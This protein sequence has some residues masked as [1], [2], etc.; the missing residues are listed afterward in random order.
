VAQ[1]RFWPM[2]AETRGKGKGPA[3][4]RDGVWRDGGA[5]GGAAT[6]TG[7]EEGAKK[8]EEAE[9]PASE[10]SSSDETTSSL[11]PNP[12]IFERI[13]KGMAEAPGG[14]VRP[15]SLADEIKAGFD[16]DDVWRPLQTRGG[17]E[18]IQSGPV[19]SRPPPRC[20]T[21]V[22]PGKPPG[23]ARRPAR[24]LTGRAACPLSTRGGTRLVRLVRGRGG[25]SISSTG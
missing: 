14:S 4:W 17:P 20:S 6:G 2:K 25:G 16:V 19:P 24:S 3:W 13:A 9:G 18:S 23:R 22:C 1:V 8:E 21:K 11:G 15:R 7:E 10:A 5:A 12:D